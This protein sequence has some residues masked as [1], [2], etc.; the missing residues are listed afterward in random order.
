[1]AELLFIKHMLT[2]IVSVVASY[3]LLRERIVKLEHRTTDNEKDVEKLVATVKENS[4]KFEESKE[5]Y[6][7]DIH[8]I[9]LTLQ[10]IKSYMKHAKNESI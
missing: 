4:N 2:A 7:N 5:S 9:K 8:E 6:Q 1:M 3:F 10:D